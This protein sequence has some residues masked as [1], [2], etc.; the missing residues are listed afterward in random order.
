MHEFLTDWLVC[1]ACHDDLVWRIEERAGAHIESGQALCQACEE[2][3]PIRDGIGVFLLPDLPRDDL[4]QD[5]DSALVKYL[6][7][8]PDVD[9]RLMGVPLESLAPADQFFRAMAAE[10]RG[11]F[12][13]ATRAETL[14]NQ[15]LYTAECRACSDSQGAYVIEQLAGYD[16]PVVDLASGR[17]H[18]VE[19]MI[20]DSDRL[21]V[22]T[23]FSLKV[24]Q[25]NRRWLKHLRQYEKVS[26]LAFDARRTPMRTGIVP[27]LTTYLGL[28]NVE[29]PGE[30]L[31]E[32]RRIVAGAFLAVS[33]FYPTDDQA[34]GQAL[35]QAGLD[36]LLFKQS[37]LDRFAESGWLAEVAN[38][39]AGPARRTPT[40]VVIEGAVIDGFPV[41]E[42]QLEWCVIEAH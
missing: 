8:K 17:G 3:Y 27:L 15:R 13:E 6:R 26:L 21:V 30:L 1:P 16:G 5:V 40:G 32:L 10:E 35:R 14:A 36:A 22:A 4:W 12:D 42:T 29:Q 23:D 18:L 37:A 24:L 20:G 31:A 19:R 25:R 38:A 7:D 2:A 34:N 39:C 28:P 33:H 9:E 41:A 11:D